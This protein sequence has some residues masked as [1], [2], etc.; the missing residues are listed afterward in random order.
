MKSD[1]PK[2]QTSITLDEDT[3][4]SV[5]AY[6][7]TYGIESTSRAIKS[8]VTEALAATPK[9]GASIAAAWRAHNAVMHVLLERTGRFYAEM[10]VLT[11]EQLASISGQRFNCPHCG[12]SL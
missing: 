11:R 2:R 12:G 7:E 5:L 10:G 4:P 9:D 1:G 6:M 3:F 8:L